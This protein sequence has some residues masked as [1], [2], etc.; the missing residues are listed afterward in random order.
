MLRYFIYNQ[1]SI[2]FIILLFLSLVI[3]SGCST[4]GNDK[5]LAAYDHSMPTEIAKLIPLPE[6]STLTAQIEEEEKKKYSVMYRPNLTYPEMVSFVS[7]NLSDYDWHIIDET[8]V[9]GEGERQSVW[10]IK[11]KNYAGKIIVSALGDENGT[12][13]N[14]IMIIT[15]E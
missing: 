10:E 9:E 15:E 13:V 4:R 14:G 2:Q 7:E 11:R 1:N 12:G 3:H 5:T 6:N 8:I